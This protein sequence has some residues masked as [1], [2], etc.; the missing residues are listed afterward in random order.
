MQII[1]AGDFESVQAA[2]DFL[3]KKPG[4]R[5]LIIPKGLTKTGPISLVSDLTIRLEEGAV[6][7]FMDDPDLYPPI[8][9]RWEGVECYAMHPLMYAA[10]CENIVI[11]GKGTIDGNGRAWW[12]KFAQIEREDRT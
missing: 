6:L 11:T 4:P 3:S 7:Q 1:N 8:W 10:D 2:I 12:K 5:E 9:T